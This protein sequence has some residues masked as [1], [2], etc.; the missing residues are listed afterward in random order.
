MIAMR[1]F[2][3]ATAVLAALVILAG[4]VIW[5]FLDTASVRAVVEARL[6]AT[7]GQP[8]SIGRLGV[9][10]FPR[11]ALSGG[12]VR[13]GETRA[14]APAVDVERVRILPY[15]GPLLRREI[16]IERV[17]L[18]GFVVSVLRDVK[19]RWHVPSTV[20]VPSAGGGAGASVERVRIANGRVR[21]FDGTANGE[22]AES[23][24]LDEVEAEVMIDAGG[25]RLAPISGRIGRATI[26]GEARTDAR[27][28][29]LDFN[30]GAI[31]DDDLPVFLR[32]LGSERPAFLRL[33]E[34]ATASAALSVDRN[35][36]RLTGKGTLRAPNVVL[37]P[38][39]LQR[40]EAPFAIDG[41]R[42][43]FTPTA[44]AMYGGTHRG[45]VTVQ[46]ADTPP[47]WATDSRISGLDIGN[48]LNALT[49]RDQRID[50]TASVNAAI[51][52]RVGEVLRRTVRG[53]TD[54]N[55]T[56][57]VVRQF[58]LLAT[59]NRTLKLAGA[60]GSDTHFERLTATLN[61]A[62]GEATTED[63]LLEAGHV[64]VQ[65]AGRIGAD[66]SLDLR[67]SAIVSAERVAGA[68][69][70]VREFAR[71]RN[72]RGEIEVPLT[73]TGSL[74]APSFG[75][76]VGAAVRQ[77]VADELRR[78]LRRFIRPPER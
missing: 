57:G 18:D 46:L 6:S 68:V 19:G 44:F 49:G 45:T 55:I 56:N 78:R 15:I 43:Q 48:F 14:Q 29:R 37:E 58:P 47:T 75:L 11:V 13:I 74:D 61:M 70:S 16:A 2:L 31:A 60:E 7:L 59:I 51:R 8:V 24:S 23:A 50:G 76:D 1:R 65:G 21:V 40:F 66:R 22:V 38:L 20:P 25:L 17:E 64:R 26:S 4:V 54:L 77:G 42:L 36:L 10:L 35:T 30:A 41:P 27:A 12:D 53:R 67:G 32:L 3:I 63:L 39:R 34:A 5:Q 9:S 71:L 52:G 33:G 62:A 72:S 28:V 69:A 73:I